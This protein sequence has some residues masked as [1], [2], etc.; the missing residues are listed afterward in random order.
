M[1]PVSDV[2]PK[3]PAS[4]KWYWLKW[5]DQELQ[6]A[7]ILTSDWST[8]STLTIADQAI[9]GQMTG[10]KVSGGVEGQYVELEVEITTSAG[11]TLHEQLVI[12]IDRH[13][14]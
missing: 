6:G 10:V 7:A 13:G 12:K 14:H 5:H 2:P 9:N 4:A 11:E 3:H 1:I 8:G